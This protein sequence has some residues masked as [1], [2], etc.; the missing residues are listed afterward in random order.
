MKA[1]AKIL[2][3]I[4]LIC[5]F[6]LIISAFSGCKE[7]TTAIEFQ[8]FGKDGTAVFYTE[9]PDEAA[10]FVTLITEALAAA[11]KDFS[12][13]EEDSQLK[14]L[15]ETGMNYVSDTLKKAL[16]DS[17]I[18]CSALGDLVDISMGKALSLWGFYSDS[19]AVPDSEEL[20]KAMA[21]Q[22]LDKLVIARDSNKVT[23]TDDMEIDMSPLAAGIALDEALNAAKFCE[24]PYLITLG[25]MTLAYGKAPRGDEWEI[26]VRNPISQEKE[27]FAAIEITPDSETDSVF[28]SASGVWE[29]SFTQDGKA[30]HS[31]LD[32]ETGYPCDNS[33][34]SV[35]VVTE[36]GITADALSD[37]LLVNGFSEKSLDYIE[38]F[39]AEAIF[40]FADK[41]YYVTEGLRDGF[42]L[43]DSSFTEHTEAPATELF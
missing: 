18:I 39:F 20:Q 3:P 22:T 12:R 42:K 15:N 26:A 8:A 30:Y 21:D 9:N 7:K 27:G 14:I 1:S 2:R 35:T 31:F 17:G 28:V 11:Q 32:P 5:I 43:R 29:N 33:L 10:P 19:P 36:S 41:T 16:E 34:V 24:V 25:D 4:A 6:C 40:V 37:A 23:I 38:C 13:T